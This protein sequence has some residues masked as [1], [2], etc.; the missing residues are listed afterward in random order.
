MAVEIVSFTNGRRKLIY[1]SF[2]Y[3]KQKDLNGG[4]I[5]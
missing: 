5:S 2:I 3:V 4:K 1:N